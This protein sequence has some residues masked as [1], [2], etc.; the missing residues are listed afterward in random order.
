MPSSNLQLTTL[1][2]EYE[3]SYNMTEL[4]QSFQFILGQLNDSSIL[5]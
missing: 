2:S 1:I 3:S 4:K 5:A